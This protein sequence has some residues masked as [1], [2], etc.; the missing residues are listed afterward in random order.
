MIC[1]A[2]RFARSDLQAR[3]VVVAAEPWAT[4]RERFARWNFRHG[5]PALFDQAVPS[6]VRL[7]GDIHEAIVEVSCRLP[8]GFDVDEFLRELPTGEHRGTVFEHVPAVRSARTD[9]A[10]RALSSA[11][12]ENGARPVPKL[13]TGDRNVVGPAWR[14]GDPAVTDPPRGRLRAG[15]HAAPGAAP[16]RPARIGWLN[17]LS[18]SPTKSL[19]RRA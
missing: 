15:R 11:T 2:A 1:A 8:A 3:V 18:R 17:S 16:G 9:P 10:V 19:S 6:L 5:G 7:G 13:G 14:S 4:A 12:R